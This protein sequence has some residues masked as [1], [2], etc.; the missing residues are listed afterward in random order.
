MLSALVHQSRGAE[1]AVRTTAR[2]Q[3][4]TQL[5][6]LAVIRVDR[7][8]GS[9]G[10]RPCLPT[11]MPRCYTSVASDT[12][13]TSTSAP[14][15]EMK[16][17][18]SEGHK[19]IEVPQEDQQSISKPLD[20]LRP[21]LQPINI[22]KSVKIKAAGGKVSALLHPLTQIQTIEKL[23][24]DDIPTY[25]DISNAWWKY[26][27]VQSWLHSFSTGA[28][29]GLLELNRS[30]FGVKVRPD[31]LAK[32]LKYERD[33]H[34]Q[35]TESSKN[36]G[37]VRGSTRKPFPQKGR[38]KARVG[39]IRA[40]QFVGG[41]AV[42]GPRPHNKATDIPRK[43]Y[44][45]GIRTA[46]STKFAQD[47]L[48]VVDLLHT[49]S[50]SK[51]TMREQLRRLDLSGRKVYFLYGSSQPTTT[52]INV[53]DTFTKA[54]PTDAVPEGERKILVAAAGHVSVSALLEYEMLVLD[55]EA[56]EVL[57]QKYRTE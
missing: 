41:Y 43:V 23:P 1:A 27:Y 14:P 38:G 32:V 19:S 33:W 54:G 21:P 2:L 28:F 52:L 45:L 49:D 17:L 44:D 47:Q 7:S 9:F 31:I 56:V 46:L 22:F 25:P 11:L 4:Y 3:I 34:E 26:P 55:K 35:G 51:T 24:M 29:L 53:M 10:S 6:P 12:T 36:L 15:P 30:V 57:E 48:I 40:P 5:V 13:L 20:K 42:H 37:Q 18:S 50:K 8:I 39:T 16:S